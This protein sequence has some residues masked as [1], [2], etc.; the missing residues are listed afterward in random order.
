L[1]ETFIAEEIASLRSRGVDIRIISLLEAD[2][3]PIQPRS[4]DLIRLTWY[5]PGFARLSLAWAQLHFVWRSPR[6]YLRLLLTLLSQPYLARPAAAF[7]KR[8]AVFAK[9]VAAA[10]YL[11]Q[12]GVQILHAHFAWLPG[13]AAWI[14]ARL[15]N[16]PFTV[17]VHAYDL[18]TLTD[19]LG[20][21]CR[22]A[23]HVVTISDYNKRELMRLGVCPGDGVSVVRSGIDLSRFRSDPPAPAVIS[24]V[25]TLRVLSIGSLIPKKGHAFLLSA[26]AI[27][28]KRGMNCRCTIIGAGPDEGFLRRLIRS[29]GLEGEAKLLGELTSREVASAHRTHDVFALACAVSP[30][31]DMDGI[32]VVLME[33]GAMGLPL[34]STLLSGIPELVRHESTGLLVPPEDPESLAD[35]LA[36]LAVNPGLRADLGRNAR[37]LVEDQYDI[38]RNAGRLHDVLADLVAQPAPPVN[39]R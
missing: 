33:A 10:R 35:A 13:A 23:R 30:D 4:R 36:A 29:L 11:E 14:I 18:Y 20:L 21:V 28:K 17:T 15:I 2:R 16:R 32:P 9:A 38:S 7:L 6:L 24:P 25:K 34:V 3:G 19:L 22:Q 31:G 39:R 1:T 5:P 26:C 37:A 12:E 8:F 27:L